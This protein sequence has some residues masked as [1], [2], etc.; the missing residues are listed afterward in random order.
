MENITILERIKMAE[1][2]AKY[3][4]KHHIAIEAKAILGT[5]NVIK[6]NQYLKRYGF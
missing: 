4:R 5:G 3:T 1:E 2:M 6:A